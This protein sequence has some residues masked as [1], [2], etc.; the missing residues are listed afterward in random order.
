MDKI[1]ELFGKYGSY[2][3]IGE[4]VSQLEHALQS[5]YLARQKH[6]RSP[7]IVACLLHDIGHLIGLKENAENMGDV[8][9]K[10]HEKLG[11]D[12]LRSLGIIEPVC[13][14]VE[15]HVQAKRYILTT[16]PQYYDRLSNASKETFKYQGGK[17]SDQE[18]NNFKQDILLPGKLALRL[19]DDQAKVRGLE[20]PNL[21][22]YIDDIEYCFK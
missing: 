9:I 6:Y 2:D 1:F 10:D 7:F 21:E 8:G 18:V 19:I 12:F 13:E 11:A 4:N 14:L 22:S 17:M 5:A 16:Q 20:V 15:S 3:Y